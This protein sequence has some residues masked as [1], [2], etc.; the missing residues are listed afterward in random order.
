MNHKTIKKE[1]STA[2]KRIAPAWPLKNQVAVNPYLG[3]SDMT[4][5]DAAKL[6]SERA[7]I[8][9]SMPIQFYLNAIENKQISFHDLQAVLNTKSSQFKSVDEF[10]KY[11]N[12]LSKRKD[13]SSTVQIKTC[14]D[15]SEEISGKHW[16]EFMIDKVSTFLSSYFDEVQSLWNTSDT[17]QNIYQA[18]KQDAEVDYSAEVMGIKN[19]RTIIQGLPDDSNDATE[20]IIQ[21]IKLTD[22]ILEPYLHTLLLKLVGWSS[23]I[24]GKDWNNS[25][26]GG[27]TTNLQALLSILLS[28]EL[29]LYENYK[30][31]GV[32]TLWNTYKSQIAEKNNTRKTD[33]TLQVKLLLQDAYD[34][35]CQG[36][37]KKKFQTHQGQDSKN[38]RPK[39]QA[40]FCIDVRSEVI[41][42]HIERVDPEIETLGFA[43]FFGFPIKYQPLAHNTSKNQCPVLIPAGPVVKET[44]SNSIE[45]EKA[46]LTRIAKHQFTKSWWRFKSGA[47]SS[48]AFVSP[49]GLTYLPKLLSDSFGLTRPTEDPNTDGLSKWIKQ[50]R[51]L[52]L[53]EIPLERKIKMAGSALSAMGLKGRMA[54]LVLI[55][56]HGSTTVNNPHATGLDCGACGGHS[57]EINAMTAERILN[58]TDVRKGLLEQGILIPN[59]THFT[60]CLHDTTTDELHIIG[61]SN[62]P[63]T[64]RELLESLKQSLLKASASSREERALRMN[65]QGKK[66]EPSIL[67][68]SKDWSQVRPE[69]GLAGCN[70]FVIAPRSR[71]TGMD[72]GGKSFLHSYTW[73]TDTEFKILE[74][75]ITAPMVV[76]SWINLQYFASTTDNARFGAGNKTLHN[77]T[78]GIGVLEGSS[79]DL[80]IGLPMQSIHDGK[81]FQH[82][83]QRLNVI[84]EAPTEAINTILSKNVD[85]QNLCDN[86]WITLLHLSEEGKITSKYLG[87]Y[88]WEDI[89]AEVIKEQHEQLISI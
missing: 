23:F 22:D 71:T 84:I 53:S 54:E 25:L 63:N 78:G 16:N 41:R 26:Y 11:A 72:L 45:T 19:F 68:R 15:A 38:S 39:A 36:Q 69:W 5:Q 46:R 21:K 80:R 73:Q 40:V 77:V 31:E 4:F 34:H 85:V 30:S 29:C 64:H 79:G 62:V 52:D 61:N 43:G 7:G 28:W 70:A 76:T 89:Q 49:L 59:D 9:M 20:H 58:D 82:L 10:L 83:P 56:G 3:L 81:D 87:D 12:A 57:G 14:L 6:L 55:T 47:V 42:R 66:I 17:T 35:A 27:S 74:A 67:R 75:I 51:D 60:A 86:G 1:I 33:E 48:F 24:A 8:H 37:L 32:E 2:C 65:I 13:L 50:G 88:E 18:W 44:F